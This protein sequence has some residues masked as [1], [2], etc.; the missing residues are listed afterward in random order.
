MPNTHEMHAFM[1][2]TGKTLEENLTY[3]IMKE[4]SAPNGKL[5][6]SFKHMLMDAKMNTGVDSL[7]DGKSKSIIH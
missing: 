3:L 2:T 7:M 5:N 6:I 1:L 4:S